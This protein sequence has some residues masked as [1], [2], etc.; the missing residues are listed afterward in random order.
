MP[1]KWEHVKTKNQQNTIESRKQV[2]SLSHFF[3]HNSLNK[4]AK[5]ASQEAAS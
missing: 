3:Q 5:S 2:P 1:P 4:P